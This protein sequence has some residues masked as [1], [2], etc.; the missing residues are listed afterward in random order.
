M[1]RTALVIA[2]HPD[3]EVLGCGGSIATMARNGWDVHILVLAEGATSRLLK[4]DRSAKAD[5]LSE[6]E[7]ASRQAGTILGAASVTLD[8]FPDNR[9]D[10]VD[11]L[12]VVKKIEEAIAKWR[13]ERLLTHHYGDVN[14]DHRIIHEAVAAACR[15]VPG[16]VVR[17]VRFFEV[18]SSTEWRPASSARAFQPNC[19]VDISDV[20]DVKLRAL[21][22]YQSELREFPHPRSLAATEHLARWR[23]AT[24]GVQAAEAF[25]IGFRVE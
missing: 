8:A 11:L 9:M 24:A 14:I 5:E 3:D 20:L 25:E 17:E 23:G 1:K 6:L 21:Q 16:S 12:D 4:R 15:P 2:A 10:S 18:A 19:F 22:A 7:T 13:P